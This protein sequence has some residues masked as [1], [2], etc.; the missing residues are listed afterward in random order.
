LGYAH[1]ADR[2][3][4]RLRR[5]GAETVALIAGQ[6]AFVFSGQS[7]FR[8]AALTAERLARPQRVA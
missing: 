4:L 7:L 5:Q 8:M 1:K 3:P 6:F 2:L